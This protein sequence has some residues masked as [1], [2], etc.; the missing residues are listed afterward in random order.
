VRLIADPA[1]LPALPDGL[2]PARGGTSIIVAYYNPEPVAD[3]LAQEIRLSDGA[4]LTE[5]IFPG[6]PRVTCPE[7]AGDFVYFTT[8]VEGM[9][10]P[11]PH[12]GTIFRAEL[13]S[14]AAH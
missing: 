7:V 5:W 10:D 12:A 3:G 4:I 8:A 2:R 1:S 13:P 9:P 6:S 14:D 11:T